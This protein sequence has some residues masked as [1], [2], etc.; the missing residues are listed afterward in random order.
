MLW[1]DG[2]VPLY[3]F[4]VWEV[5]LFIDC[6]GVRLHVEQFGTGGTP[7]LLLH[8]WGCSIRHFAP[9]TEDLK[10]D[11]LV[12]VLDFPAHGESSEPPEPWGVSDFAEMTAEV[13]ERLSIAPA[14]I[15]AHSFGA[16]VAID[17]A[18][19]HPALVNRM[20]LTG[21]AG[22][23]KPP[24]PEQKKKSEQYQRKKALLSRLGQLPGL[25]TP[26]EK[27]LE[28]ERQKH[29]SPDYLALSPQMRQ[30]FVKIVNEDLSDRLPKIKASTL[31]VFGQNDTETPLWMGQRM[32]QEIPDAGLVVFE[33]GDHFAYL[34]E[35]PRFLTIV[36]TF[37]N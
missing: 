25:K 32:E 15:I 11:R 21:A 12:T 34:Q 7:V 5:T 36:R 22:I 14:D 3:L 30:T 2:E 27:L 29:G 6:R 18:A 33:N 10:K 20:V 28:A 8:G 31:L 13:M 24:T 1:L 9:I 4:S 19:R 17:L 35:W 26:M 16:R 23:R 37:L